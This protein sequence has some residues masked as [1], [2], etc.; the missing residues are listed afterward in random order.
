MASGDRTFIQRILDNYST[1]DDGMVGDA[2]RIGFMM[3]QFGPS[4]MPKRRDNVT[5]QAAC[6]KYQ[7]KVDQ[8]KF[9]RVMTLATAIWSLQ[10]LAGHDD[11]IKKTLSEFLARDTRLKTL[12]TTEQVALGN[13]I[14]AIAGAN[15]FK[16]DHAGTEHEQA[17]AAMSKS[18]SIYENLGPTNEA[19]A[20]FMGLKK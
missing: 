1:A 18:A 3:T 20:P 11:G 10:S 12:F 17:Y 19:I 7:C 2:L 4:L 13:Y 5:A 16:D 14:A 8:T 6:A 15:A 9:F